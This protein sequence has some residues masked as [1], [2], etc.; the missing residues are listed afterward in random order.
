M[1]CACLFDGLTGSLIMA[2][3]SLP[4]YADKL[5]AERTLIAYVGRAHH[6]MW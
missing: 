4:A 1:L 3:L 5:S 6:H 2:L